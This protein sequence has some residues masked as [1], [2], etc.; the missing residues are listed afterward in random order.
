MYNQ[1]CSA[2]AFYMYTSLPYSTVLLHLILYLSSTLGCNQAC[3]DHTFSGKHASCLVNPRAGQELNLIIKPVAS[4]RQQNLAVVGA[5]PAGKW[6]VV[7]MMI[8]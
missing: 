2:Y 6:R 1:A 8:S 3:L 4:G 5:G 7:M